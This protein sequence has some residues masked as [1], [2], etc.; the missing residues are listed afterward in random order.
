M[1]TSVDT[2]EEAHQLEEEAR[3]IFAALKFDLR[4][5][6]FSYHKDKMSSKVLGMKWDKSTD[7]VSVHIGKLKEFAV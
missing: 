3:A 4:G 6:E 5:W 7:S 2:L 1:C